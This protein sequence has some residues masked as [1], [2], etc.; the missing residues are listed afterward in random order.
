MSNPP[1]GRSSSAQWYISSYMNTMIQSP[2]SL[3]HPSP[4]KYEFYHFMQPEAQK[5]NEDEQ[6]TLWANLGNYMGIM[7]KFMNTNSQ[8]RPLQEFV[9]QTH[10]CCS[11]EN[12]E[13]ASI[14]C[15]GWGSSSLTNSSGTM[16]SRL[17]RSRVRWRPANIPVPMGTI[18]WIEARSGIRSGH[19]MAMQSVLEGCR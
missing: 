13:E 15:W 7:K 4:I 1:T 12:V 11:N 14:V 16:C 3:Q 8:P 10:L 6:K 9:C 2:H 5:L 18:S 19:S 17:Q